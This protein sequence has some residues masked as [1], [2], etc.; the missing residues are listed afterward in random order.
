MI[1][2]RPGVA[3]DADAL[4]RHCRQRLAAYKC[5]KTYEFIGKLPMSAAGKV[6]KSVLRQNHVSRCAAVAAPANQ[7]NQA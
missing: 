1:V 6:L 4:D 2:P 7:E 3:A 5:P